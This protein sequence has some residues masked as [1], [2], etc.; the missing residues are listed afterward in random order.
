MWN[1][2]WDGA[3]FL[4]CALS[5]AMPFR[6][7]ATLSATG[8]EALGCWRVR[9]GILC[10]EAILLAGSAVI[11]AL[12]GGLTGAVI[13]VIAAIV[14]GLV[15]F[16]FLEK[17]LES[18]QFRLSHFYSNFMPHLFCHVSLFLFLM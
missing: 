6:F 8:I 2:K 13:G 1:G 16:L 15:G 11:G 4:I 17:C 5:L 10:F 9:N 12:L 18:R 7:L 14:S 3:Q